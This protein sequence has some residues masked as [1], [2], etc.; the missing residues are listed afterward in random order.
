MSD[1]F[2]FCTVC[3]E[4]TIHVKDE[5]MVCEEKRLKAAK[6]FNNFDFGQCDRATL[7]AVKHVIQTKGLSFD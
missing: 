7:K 4:Q 1:G 6:F 2:K 5:C 3:N